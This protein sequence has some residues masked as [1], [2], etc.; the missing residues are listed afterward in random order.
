MT[1]GIRGTTVDFFVRAN[2]DST[3]VLRSGEMF[4]RNPA[5]P[6]QQPTVVSTPGQSITGTTGGPLGPPGPPPPDA[7]QSFSQLPGAQL[8]LTTTT[9]SPFTSTTTGTSPVP[10]RSYRDALSAIGNKPPEKICTSNG[11][12]GCSSSSY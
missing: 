8:G 12:H 10:A 3:A 11:T 1:V 5:F 6:N 9:L 4:V 2:G 7:Q